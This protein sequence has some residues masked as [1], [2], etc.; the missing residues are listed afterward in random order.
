[1]FSGDD[2]KF[3]QHIKHSLLYCK[4]FWQ[5]II[6]FTNYRVNDLLHRYNENN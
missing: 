3:Y 6:W 2:I 4:N 5:E 1:M